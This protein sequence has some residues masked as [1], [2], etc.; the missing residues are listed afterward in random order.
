M[1]QR[2]IVLTGVGFAVGVAEALVYYNMGKSEGKAFR[3]RFPPT[4][5]FVKTAGVVLLTSVIT[6]ALFEGIKMVYEPVEDETV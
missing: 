1:K 2:G 3:F 4:R 5:D 6:T